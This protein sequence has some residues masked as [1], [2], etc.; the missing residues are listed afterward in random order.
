MQIQLIRSATLRITYAGHLF[1]IDPYLAAKHSLPSYAGKSLNPLVDLPC[2]PQE[3]LTNIEMVVIS[4]L[5]SDHFDQAARAV[6][7][8]DLPIFCQPG[9]QALI[10]NH[11]FQHVMPIEQSVVWNGII[12]TRTPAQ[13]GKGEVLADMGHVSGFI[14]QH[15]KEPTLYWAGDTIWYEGVKETI[16]Q[17]RPD[18]IVTHSCGATWKQKGYIV[19]DAEQTVAVCQVAPESVVVATH[20]DSVDHATIS[21]TDLRTFAS[22]HGIHDTHLLIPQD[23]ETLTF[24]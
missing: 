1:L 2:A 15:E 7:A 4:H 17:V 14:F 23:G 6:L 16:E 9:D 5:H 13:H 3:V 22:K 19:M 20:M 24:D 18:V 10:A 11:G 8:R 21:R 12:I